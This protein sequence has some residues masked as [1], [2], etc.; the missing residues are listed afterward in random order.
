MM[1]LRDRATDVLPTQSSMS[2]SRDC[3]LREQIQ[4]VERRIERSLSLFRGV[5]LR[6]GSQACS[7]LLES[8]TA[9]S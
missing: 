9:I 1:M 3:S 8:F 7:C 5:C 6:K 4:V 2:Q